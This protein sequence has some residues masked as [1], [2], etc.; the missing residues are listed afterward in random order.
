MVSV[1]FTPVALGLKYLEK[2]IDKA[3]DQ[4]KNEAAELLA[5]KEQKGGATY[6]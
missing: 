2:R 5:V 4:E 6:E 1:L 3:I